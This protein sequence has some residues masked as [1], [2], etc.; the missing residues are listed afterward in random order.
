MEIKLRLVARWK[1]FWHCVWTIHACETE[2]EV[3]PGYRFVTTS[4]KCHTCGKDFG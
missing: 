3:G 4:V 1:R 2:W